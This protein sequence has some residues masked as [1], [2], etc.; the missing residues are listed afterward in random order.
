MALIAVFS[1]ALVTA[2]ACGDDDDDDD[3][4]DDAAGDDDDDDD[5]GGSGDPYADCVDFYDSCGLDGATY[6][7]GFENIS[8]AGE[9]IE[10]AVSNVL[11]CYADAGCDDTA[12]L[13]ACA[14][15]YTNEIADCV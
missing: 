1:M 13:T 3:D 6:C 9:C 10:T 14:E 8:G 2:V 12:A 7:S 5:D 11:A 15:A 4:D